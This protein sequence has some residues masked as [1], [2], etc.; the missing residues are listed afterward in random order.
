MDSGLFGLFCFSQP[1]LLRPSSMGFV[2][3]VLYFVTYYLTPATVFGPLAAAHIEL[4][5]AGVI[6]V[7]SV[8]ALTKTYIF[9]TPQSLA[10]VG[11]TVSVFLSVLIG[12]RWAGGG[13][14]AFQAFI[15]NAFGYFLVCLHFNSKKKLQ[16]M[17]LMLLFSCLLVI[18]HGV[19][20]LRHGLTQNNGSQPLAEGTSI[21]AG[22]TSSPYFLA[23]QSDSG[24]T[25]FRLRGLGEIND[26][27]DF[28]QLIVC[29]IPLVFIFWRPKRQFL[30][31]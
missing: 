14:Q 2:L 23:Q 8:P 26:P 11:L 24:E 18:G 6:V 15:P 30:N 13:V 29:I 10:L 7:V 12:V 4:I 1:G 3:S 25:F 27:N 9:R 28:A 22:A 19:Q 5:L 17:V 16:V 31:F 21:V 20:D